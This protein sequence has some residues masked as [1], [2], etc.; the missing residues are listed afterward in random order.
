M[1]YIS[2]RN[3]HKQASFSDAVLQGLADDG[4]LYV[5]QHFPQLWDS[6]LPN[7]WPG[8]TSFA[9][10]AFSHFMQEDFSSAQIEAL[11]AS[12]YQGFSTPTVTPVESYGRYQVLELFHGPTLAFKDIALQFLGQ[13]FSQLL[14]QEQRSI[15]VLAA[16]S[17]DT[18][19]A[20]IAGLSNLSHCQVFVLYPDQRVSEVQELQMT[21]GVA[22]NIF[23]LVLKGSFDDAQAIVK[24]LFSDP[25]FNQ[26]VA[27]GAVN[28]INWCRIM[29]QMI[30]YFSAACQVSRVDNLSFAVPTGN[31]GDVLAGYYAHRSGLPVKQFIVACNEND[32]LARLYTDG[33]Y[34]PGLSRATLSPAMDIQVASN[35]ERLLFELADRDCEYVNAKMKQLAE[36]G[37]YRLEPELMDRFRELFVVYSVSDEQTRD[38]MREL[39]QLGCPVD[40]HTAVGLVAADHCGDESTVCLS[41]AHPVKFEETLVE[42]CQSPIELPTSVAQLKNKPQVRYPIENDIRQVREFILQ[43]QVSVS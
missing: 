38:K 19:G 6:E 31:F 12:A 21:A 39:S 1:K 18:G 42:V 37:E 10:Q 15:S 13:V 41:T 14:E 33:V 24:Q 4:G 35:F 29:A 36:R 22:D 3:K 9:N 23:P 7:Q 30:Y 28:S 16:T 34:A 11:T 8:Y 17:G 5:P 26:Q 2:T 43:H 32:L 25:E 40:P 20:A 27:L